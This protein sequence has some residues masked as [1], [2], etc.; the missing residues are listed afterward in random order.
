MCVS[1]SNPMLDTHSG[2]WGALGSFLCGILFTRKSRLSIELRKMFY[3]QHS[4]FHMDKINIIV[5]S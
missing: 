1:L 2:H 5:V 3:L 4:N